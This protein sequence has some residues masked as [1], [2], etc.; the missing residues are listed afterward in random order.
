MENKKLKSLDIESEYVSENSFF[1]VKNSSRG[2]LN[3]Y[4]ME[5]LLEK[6]TNETLTELKLNCKN[7]IEGKK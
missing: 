5:I 7:K 2:E 4:C 3:P 6:W 1:G